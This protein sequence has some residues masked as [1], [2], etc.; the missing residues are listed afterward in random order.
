MVWGIRI[1]FIIPS[2][3][4]NIAARTDDLWLRWPFYDIG[5]PATKKFEQVTGGLFMVMKW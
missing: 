2:V 1:I 5:K 3:V 4:D